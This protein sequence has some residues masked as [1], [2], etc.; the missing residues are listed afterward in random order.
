MSHTHNHQEQRE[1]NS[2]MLN[3]NLNFSTLVQV[4]K[5]RICAAHIRT[6]LSISINATR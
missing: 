6:G 1:M 3:I 2:Y 4:P 5:L